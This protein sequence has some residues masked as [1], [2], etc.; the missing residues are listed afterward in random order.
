MEITEEIR[1]THLDHFAG[2]DKVLFLLV[3]GEM[4]EAFYV[5]ENNQLVRVP[6]HF[7]YYEKNDAMQ[8]YMSEQR[9]GAGIEPEGMNPLRRQNM[10]RIVQ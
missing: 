4:E 8:A 5:Y 7:I 6:G 9:G 1:K 2:N 3:P 10:Y